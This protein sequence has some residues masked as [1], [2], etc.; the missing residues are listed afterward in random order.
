VIGQVTSDFQSLATIAPGRFRIFATTSY[1]DMIEGFEVDLNLDYNPE[2]IKEIVLPL[3]QPKSKISEIPQ[4][5]LFLP[6]GLPFLNG[7]L[8]EFLE[9]PQF[10]ESL[11]ILYVVVTRYIPDVLLSLRIDDICNASN[12]ERKLLLSPV[13]IAT[14]IS[15]SHVACLLGYLGHGGMK[16]DEFSRVMAI[17]TGFVPLICGLW[18][19]TANDGVLGRD[20]VAVT[21]GLYG[22]AGSLLPSTLPPDRVFEYILRCS[23]F[24]L[25]GGTPAEQDCVILPINKLDIP[26]ESNDPL[27]H[28]CRITHQPEVVIL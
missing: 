12:D 18:R 9:V 1:S 19:I 4:L 7:T 8:R 13:V 6:G 17:F 26:S 11:H 10:E 21:A 5:H 27:H 15:Y 28:Y 23:T 22:F 25:H 16:G 3:L 14:D 24:V 20:V 2:Q